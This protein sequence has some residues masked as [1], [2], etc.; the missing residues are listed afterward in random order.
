MLSYTDIHNL[1]GDIVVGIVII[2]IVW[3]F[4][5]EKIQTKSK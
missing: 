3:A 2:I 4:F 1:I 5:L